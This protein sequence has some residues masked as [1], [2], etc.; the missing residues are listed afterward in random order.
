M[1]H[2]NCFP[3]YWSFSNT[4]TLLGIFS[5]WSFNLRTFSGN[6]FGFGI[7]F[8]CTTELTWR[9]V[10]IAVSWMCILLRALCQHT[11]K[12]AQLYSNRM[13]YLFA[14]QELQVLLKSSYCSSFHL[15]LDDTCHAVYC[16][17]SA[18]PPEQ[19]RTECIIIIIVWLILL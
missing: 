11:R 2:I 19:K 18:I 8:K 15:Y 17:L 6:S 16:S 12:T 10:T 3:M 1:Q 13:L 4:D 14:I 5:F 9:S 7:D